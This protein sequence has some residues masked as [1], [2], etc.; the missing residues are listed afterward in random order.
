[1]QLALSASIPKIKC[2][3]C[4]PNWRP[5]ALLQIE[6]NAAYLY[7]EGI[8]PIAGMETGE[9]GEKAEETEPV[10]NSG[11]EACQ[12]EN[13]RKVWQSAAAREAQEYMIH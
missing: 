8:L 5:T 12:V 13:T 3:F 6:L 4:W 7:G 9:A 1:M 11:C 2:S 10:S